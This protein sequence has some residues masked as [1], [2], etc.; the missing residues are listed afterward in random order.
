[1]IFLTFSKQNVFLTINLFAEFK[2]NFYIC[3][4]NEIK[5]GGLKDIIFRYDK[6]CSKIN[7]KIGAIY[8]KT[9]T[10]TSWYLSQYGNRTLKSL[11]NR[12]LKFTMKHIRKQNSS[13]C[14]MHGVLGT[15]INNTVYISNEKN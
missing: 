9:F 11:L 5:S 3:I 6:E 2:K 1:M 12:S 13:L 10:R 4:Q 14:S 7:A 8:F 15:Q